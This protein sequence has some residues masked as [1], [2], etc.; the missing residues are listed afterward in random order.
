MRAHGWY[1]TETDMQ[2]RFDKDL[3]ATDA[4]AFYSITQ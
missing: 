2:I 4:L 3:D 1:C